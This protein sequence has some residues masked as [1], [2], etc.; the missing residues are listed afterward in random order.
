MAS[1]S[2]VCS[3]NWPDLPM[4]GD[5]QR[6]RC[7]HQRALAVELAG[8][9]HLVDPTDVE[10]AE[11]AEQHGRADEQAHVADPDREERLERRSLF[12][13]SSHQ[14]PI[15]MNEQRPMIS[16]PRISCTMFGASTIS[17][18]PAEKR[19]RAAKKCV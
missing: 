3:G 19:V 17:S 14:C 6:D 4:H 18:M 16:Q 7:P 15:S 1:G 11:D 8:G 9:G 13:S 12:A 5:E 10:R 2:H